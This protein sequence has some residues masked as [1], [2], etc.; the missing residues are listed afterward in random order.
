LKA[1]AT[2]IPIDLREPSVPAPVLGTMVLIVGDAMLFAG[3][4]FAFWVL[5]LAAPTWPPP[6]Q[7][8]LPVG[9]T[10]ANTV[11]LLASSAAMMA[12][13]R[14]LARGP[15]RALGRS[16][17]VCALLGSLFLTVQGYEWVRLVGFGL[18]IASG[19]YGALFY[20]LIGAHAV[21]VLAALVW[22]G[23]TV[24]HAARDQFAGGRVDRVRACALYWHYVVVLWPLLYASVYLL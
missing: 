8:R 10:T 9:L 3:L 14:D 17:G 24:I 1:V 11:V 4:V 20:T 12:A 19:I 6:L 5:R 23:L 18:T 21:H 13:T 22:L 2:P 16:L 7:P 15:S